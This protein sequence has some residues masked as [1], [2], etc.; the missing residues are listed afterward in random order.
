[1]KTTGSSSNLWSWVSIAGGSALILLVLNQAV[2]SLAAGS[3]Q[4]SSSKYGFTAH[5]VEA[6]IYGALLIGSVLII[7]IGIGWRGAEA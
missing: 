2:M 6:A 1:M 7:G 5:G 3:L 4:F